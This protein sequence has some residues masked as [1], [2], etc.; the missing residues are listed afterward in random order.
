MSSKKKDKPA[1]AMSVEKIKEL[2][3]IEKKHKANKTLQ[4]DLDRD[5]ESDSILTVINTWEQESIAKI[6]V[7][8]NIAAMSL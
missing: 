7:P 4:K 6:S 5:N 1:K 8:M 2:I 3:Q